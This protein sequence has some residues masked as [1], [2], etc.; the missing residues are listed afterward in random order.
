M[1][2]DDFEAAFSDSHN[3]N[4]VTYTLIVSVTGGTERGNSIVQEFRIREDQRD[5]VRR[6]IPSENEFFFLVLPTADDVLMINS[7]R[8]IGLRLLWDLHALTVPEPKA[9]KLIPVPESDFGKNA[10]ELNNEDIIGNELEEEFDSPEPAMVFYLAE[11]LD[12]YDESVLSITDLNV[13]DVLNAA[14]DLSVW[15]PGDSLFH[16]LDD[17]GEDVW[18]N[19]MNI[20]LAKFKTTSIDDLY[21]MVVGVNNESE[22][23]L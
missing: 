3:M 16:I 18:L 9:D 2:M 5:L 20:A 14:V 22:D 13:E 21:R 6:L 12:D 10:V 1:D 15:R 7:D 23:D 17:D 19:P 8:L 4:V 11:N